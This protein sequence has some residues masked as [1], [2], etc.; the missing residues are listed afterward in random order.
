MKDYA[1]DN[2]TT[3]CGN[4]NCPFKDCKLHLNNI[5]KGAEYIRIIWVDG[6]CRRYITHLIE[7]LSNKQ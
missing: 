4:P 1:R 6:T 2:L 7:R 3:Y 5:D